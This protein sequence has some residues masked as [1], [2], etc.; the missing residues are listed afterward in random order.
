MTQRKADGKFASALT[1][2]R[3]AAIVA[4]VARGL[5]DAQIAHKNGIDVTTLKSWIDR[6]I[7]EEAEEPFR[8]FAEDY[9]RA[10]IELEER[11][12]RTILEASEPW[13]KTKETNETIRG[14]FDDGDCDSSDRDFEPVRMRKNKR[15]RSGERGDWKA[16]AWYLERRWPLRWGLTRQPEGGPKEAI[17]LPEAVQNRRRRVDEMT[18]APPPELLKM[19]AAKGWEIR[20]REESKP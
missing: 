14:S 11:R 15:E 2:K 17:R 8:S 1:K 13:E 5:F 9:I 12:V 10:A 4:D 6:G 3:H 7:D 19:F 18:D 16:A 20:R